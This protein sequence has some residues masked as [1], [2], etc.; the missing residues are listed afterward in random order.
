MK[1]KTT[2]TN[3]NNAYDKSK[4][5]GKQSNFILFGVREVI[6]ESIP[7]IPGVKHEYS[8]QSIMHTHSHL[9]LI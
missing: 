4:T 6:P 3:K 9:R 1:K 5:E 7:G 8:L 2:K